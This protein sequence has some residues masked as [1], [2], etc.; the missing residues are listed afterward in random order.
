MANERFFL[1]IVAQADSQ[2][3]CDG[4]QSRPSEHMSAIMPS[5]EDLSPASAKSNEVFHL[6]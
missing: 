6:A 4:R 5:N 1:G 2:S 3:F